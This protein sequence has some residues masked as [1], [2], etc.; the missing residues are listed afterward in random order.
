L[1]R[2]R[3][4]AASA[5]YCQS[6][7]C[8]HELFVDLPGKSIH[9][10]EMAHVFAANDKGPRGNPELSEPERGTFENLILLCSTCHTMIVPHPVV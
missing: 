6:P 1:T 5:G 3:L 8:S 10:A 9:V 7:S 4:F 2:A